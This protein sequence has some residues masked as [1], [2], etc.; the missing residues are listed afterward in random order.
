MILFLFLFLV[1]SSKGGVWT[2]KKK[3]DTNSKSDLIL[4]VL[5]TNVMAQKWLSKIQSIMSGGT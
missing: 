3:S 1:Q 4:C 2:K 5:G